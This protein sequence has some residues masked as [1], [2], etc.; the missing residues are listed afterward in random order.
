MLTRFV[1]AKEFAD[2][3]EESD[4][5]GVADGVGEFKSHAY[6]SFDFWRLATTLWDARYY[7]KTDD[8]RR[9]ENG[10]D[11]NTLAIPAI[12]WGARTVPRAHA[13]M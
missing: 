9:A 2:A 5:L 4:L 7:I 12:T 1:V 11:E 10:A 13:V 3:S 8:V 6:K